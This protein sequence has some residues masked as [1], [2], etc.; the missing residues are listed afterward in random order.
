VVTSA[1]SQT[2][3]E[4]VR[5]HSIA[6]HESQEQQEARERASKKIEQDHQRSTPSYSKLEGPLEREKEKLA[7]RAFPGKALLLEGAAIGRR[8]TARIA[9]FNDADSGT[10]HPWVSIGPSN[11]IYPVATS[12]TNFPYSASG[13]ISALAIDPRCN[14]S[15]HDDEGDRQCRLY[16]GAAGGGVWRTD[17]AFSNNPKWTFTSDGFATNAIGFLAI[18]PYN[19]DAVYAGTG[20]PNSSADSAAGLGIYRSD[21]GGESWHRLHSTLTFA[22]PTGPVTVSD[23]FNNLSIADIVF[24]PRDTQAFYVATTLGIRGASATEGAVLAANLAAPSLYKTTDGGQT[25]NEVWNGGGA[26]CAPA[27]AGCLS[28]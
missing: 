14:K 9:V 27:G 17:Q 19:P 15:Y 18:N 11:A 1:P 2:V 4:K 13:R 20:E 28:S 26:L 24:D 8:E 3:Q 5:P 25:F 23:G 10:A 7:A 6:E 12:R 22:G 21:D 16:V